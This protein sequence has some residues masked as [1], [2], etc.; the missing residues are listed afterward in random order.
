M[1]EKE[2]NY[3]RT[4]YQGRQKNSTLCKS[5]RAETPNALQYLESLEPPTFIA[6][7]GEGY[8]NPAGQHTYSMLS[9]GENT[10][11]CGADQLEV[12]HI[13]R[14]LWSGFLADPDA[15]F[16]GFYLGYDFTQWTRTLPEKQAWLLWH[17][18]GVRIR[19]R[20]KGEHAPPFPVRW[21]DWEFD[22]LGSKRFK[23][24][25]RT[26]KRWMFI[27]DVGPYFQTSFLKAIDPG[28]WDRPVC[29]PEEYDIVLEGKAGR[30]NVLTS[31]DWVASIPDT[32]RYNL[33]ENTILA[34][35]VTR[36]SEGLRKEDIHLKRN[37]W[38][39]PGQAAGAWM[40][41]IGVIGSAEVRDRTPALVL[42]FAQDSYY[43]G[44]FEIFQHGHLPGPTYEYDI[45]SAYPAAMTELPCLEHSCWTDTEGDHGY[46]LVHARVYG[47]DPVVG[48][49][50]A[51]RPDGSIARP[52][53]VQGIYWLHEI[54]MAKQAGLIDEF[55]M[56][57]Y[58]GLMEPC[59]CNPFRTAIPEI[60][61]KRLEVGKNTPHGKALKV[62]YNSAYGKLAQSIGS[63]KYANP[64]Y[65]SL[66][67][68][69]TRTKILHAIAT[70]PTGTK[71]LAMVATD[72]I[73]FRQEHGGLEI[74]PTQLGAW[75]EQIR[76]DMCLF[77]PG[78]WWDA[79]T[80]HRIAIGKDPVLKSRGIN[81]QDLGQAIGDIDRAFHQ[82]RWWDDG[83]P[84][85]E[86]KIRFPHISAKAA[87]TRN[88]WNTAGTISETEN[89][90]E[91][92]DPT[93][94]RLFI[95][96]HSRVHPLATPTGITTPYSQTFGMDPLEH[97]DAPDPT[98]LLAP[99]LH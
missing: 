78:V 56:R 41:N 93:S 36:L 40:K 69:L 62:I 9:V 51:R 33:L 12:E 92:A 13:F 7:D 95:N 97:P 31:K 65:A 3:C 91:S 43:G 25:H 39:G 90:T 38:F 59:V 85:F 14:F 99:L 21:Q 1:Y 57:E 63:P 49:M 20:K 70:H 73:Y 71:T 82:P 75:D 98:S 5:C 76:T 50:P 67:T 86:V 8:T 34:R 89:R 45:N 60:Y 26:S 79:E 88:A 77:K 81:A 46:A 87:I 18:Q 54:Q 68:S 55:Q 11:E 37:Q 53:E 96:G 83:Y 84:A 6:V 64:I 58:W 29:T 30:G 17:A 74:H 80:R 48:A 66:I 10:L 72:G 2:C 15:T 52:Y 24:R 94:K 61:Q 44:W 23:L 47:S 32:S 35:L 16:V 4:T 42:Q 22:V 27:N 19:E 28:A